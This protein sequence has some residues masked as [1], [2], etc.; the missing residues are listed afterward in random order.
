LV[1]Y[2]LERE[3]KENEE[4][5]KEKGERRRHFLIDWMGG[6]CPLPEGRL[7]VDGGEAEDE[8]LGV[9]EPPVVLS[10]PGPDSQ[11]M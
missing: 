5:R 11:V 9:T 7:V 2:K 10:P 1:I 8:F 6:G 4:K 3:W